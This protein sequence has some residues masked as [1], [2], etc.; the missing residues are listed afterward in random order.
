MK[1]YR[2]QLSHALCVRPQVCQIV[3]PVSDEWQLLLPV[4]VP[5]QYPV[6]ACHAAT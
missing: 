6:V 4:N 5:A 1:L 3:R 2:I